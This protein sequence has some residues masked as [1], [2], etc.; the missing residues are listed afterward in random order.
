MSIDWPLV[1]ALTGLL[2]GLVSILRRHRNA[3]SV[4]LL[5]IL[6][7]A[8]IVAISLGGLPAILG[9]A[10]PPPIELL[11]RIVVTILAYAAWSAAIVWAVA[12][13]PRRPGPGPGQRAYPL[14]EYEVARPRR[15]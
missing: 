10:A 14:G 13:A 1:F 5:G 11:I 12:A 15:D 2:P 8:P 7:I 6:A 4:G 3:L 9:E